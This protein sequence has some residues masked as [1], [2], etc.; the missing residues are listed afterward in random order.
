MRST[1]ESFLRGLRS[2]KPGGQCSIVQC[3]APQKPRPHLVKNAELVWRCLSEG[4][5][6]AR[7]SNR[8]SD[9]HFTPKQKSLSPF[10]RSRRSDSWP[11]SKAP[12]CC[13]RAWEKRD[14]VAYC[15]IRWTSARHKTRRCCEEQVALS[16]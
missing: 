15:R 11:G 8:A 10:F 1:A 16:P 2:R 3:A 9:N 6:C 12:C 14:L 4:A 5:L 7:L 13:C